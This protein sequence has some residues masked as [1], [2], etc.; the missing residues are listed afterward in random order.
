MAHNPHRQAALVVADSWM[1]DPSR[2][3]LLAKAY[4]LTRQE[5][6]GITTLREVFGQPYGGWD[7]GQ[8]VALAC[9]DHMVAKSFLVLSELHIG[10]TPRGDRFRKENQAALNRLLPPGTSVMV[11]TSQRGAEMDGWINWETSVPFTAGDG[12]TGEIEAGEAP[13]EIGSTDAT[14]TCLHLCRHGTVARWAYGHRK[15]QLFDHPPERVDQ[16]GSG[17]TVGR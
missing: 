7:M 6:P 12:T 11:D 9:L 13:L 5:S 10:E 15:V 2:Q 3:P 4:W 16:R 14:T 17:A 8:L 1:N